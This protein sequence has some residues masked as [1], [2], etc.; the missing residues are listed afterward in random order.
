MKTYNFIILVIFLAVPLSQAGETAK[1]IGIEFSPFTAMSAKDD[2]VILTLRGNWLVRRTSA[3]EEAKKAGEKIILKSD[4]DL[5]LIER[6]TQILVRYVVD[7]GVILATTFDGR[8]FG[9]V[10]KE[11]QEIIKL[12][13]NQTIQPTR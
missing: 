9:N 12:K 3:N 1:E 7:E 8:S 5:T 10:I 11:H 4:S 2:S 13:P 6:H